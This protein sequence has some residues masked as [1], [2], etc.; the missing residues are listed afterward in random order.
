V[1]SVIKASQGSLNF[2]YHCKVSLFSDEIAKMRS[3]LG[4]D[5]QQRAS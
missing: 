3:N 2:R 5:H 1:I 4:P